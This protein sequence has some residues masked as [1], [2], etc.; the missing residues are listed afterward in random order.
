M[1]I[2]VLFKDGST[3]RYY[4]VE[5]LEGLDDMVR[6]VFSDGKRM[7]LLASE[8]KRITESL[9]VRNRVVMEM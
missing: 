8:I 9:G 4:G 5:S 7:D 6:L 3:M 2:T 1:H